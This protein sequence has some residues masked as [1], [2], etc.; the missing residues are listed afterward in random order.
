M[1]RYFSLL[2]L[3]YYG[4]ILNA[5]KPLSPR[6]A[7]YQIDLELDTANHQI[8]AHQTLTFK[9]PSAD[10]IYTMPFHLYYN[11]FKNNQTSFN[12][13]SAR[14]PRSKSE[15][16]IEQCEWAWIE[17]TKIIDEKGQPLNAR[18]IQPDNNNI[19]DHT[20]LEIQLE[21]PVMP[22]ATYQL[23]MEWHSQIPKMMIRTGYNR[24]FY[25]MA[26]WFPKLGVYEPAGMRFSRKG[27]WNCHQYHANTEY[28]GE[29]GV[30][31]VSMT[32]PEQYVVGASGALITQTTSNGWT[33][34]TYQAEDVIDF[35]W[36]ACPRF[37]EVLDRWED[38]NIRLLISPEHMINKERF[39]GAAKNSLSFF[40]EYLEKYPYPTL[41]IV[42][43]PYYG[44]FS[45]AMEYPTLITAPTLH[46]LPKGIRTSETL[47]IHELTHQYFMQMVA[48]NEQEEPWMDEGFTAFFEAKIMDQFYPEGIVNMWG[49]QIG[50]KEFRRGRFF[51]ADNIQVNPLSDFGWHF[52]HGSY[53]E[54]V[55]GKAA[56][57]LSTLEG[58]VGEHVMQKIMQNYFSKWKFKHPCRDDFITIALEITEKELGTSS[59]QTVNELLQQAIFGT[60]VC[61][62]SVHSISNH[63]LPPM[64]G[65]FADNTDCETKLNRDIPIYRSSVILFRQTA[66]Q[67]PV[68]VAVTFDDGS[69]IL[70]KWD[71]KTRSYE[72]SYQGQKQVIS[73]YIDP[74]FKLPID[75]NRINNSYTLTPA[76]AGLRA[77]LLNATR[78]LQ[79]LMANLSMLV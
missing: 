61:D 33:T 63:E 59:K 58:I 47:T 72:L 56:V 11:A 28:Y 3:L 24:D 46:D 52:E 9:N 5:Q 66:F 65:L 35:T 15:E 31:E 50:S 20:V 6:T 19:N 25:F 71:G 34:H 40:A 22:Y 51:N 76:K 60:E 17:V 53:S 8:N 4:T 2:L 68:E 48:T 7:N 62:Y 30:Y 77:Y 14:I 26:Q 16:A 49:I 75:K 55:Y 18:Y 73:A 42:C 32:V 69:T 43:P 10:T 64:Q 57:V 78:W 79:G 38:V 12:I 41:T 37:E 29:F 21:E 39:L 70:E 23:E 13:S 36:T 27:Q 44:L 1:T 45:G 74:D 54:I 67:L